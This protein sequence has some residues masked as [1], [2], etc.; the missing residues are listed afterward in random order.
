MHKIDKT[1]WEDLRWG[2]GQHTQFLEKYRDQWVAIRNKEVVAFGS[3]LAGVK[4]K[5]QKKTGK[6]DVPV[7]FVDCGEHIYV[8]S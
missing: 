4:K 8:Q 3:N 2:E 5:A 7:V 6:R 1:F